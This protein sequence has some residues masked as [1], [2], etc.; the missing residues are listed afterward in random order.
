M[1]FFSKQEKQKILKFAKLFHFCLLLEVDAF[2]HIHDVSNLATPHFHHRLEL[3][4]FYAFLS[5]FNF[6]IKNFWCDFQK[7]T[8]ET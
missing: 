7:D 4:F 2:T 8:D 6:E 1:S 3:F 5:Q